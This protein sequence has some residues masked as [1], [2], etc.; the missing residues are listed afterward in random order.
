MRALDLVGPI[1]GWEAIRHARR[2]KTFLLRAGYVALLLVI[3]L[4]VRSVVDVKIGT[5]IPDEAAV[6]HT[7]FLWMTFV[8]LLA[9]LILTPNYVATPIALE[10]E[11]RTFDHLFDTHLS[12]REI[13]LGKW[14]G[15]TLTVL[16]F[17]LAGAPV[18]A[19]STFL[20]GVDPL[21][22]TLLTIVTLATLFSASAICLFVSIISPTVKASVGNGQWAVV[23]LLLILPCVPWLIVAALRA[24]G[25]WIDLGDT[26]ASVLTTLSHYTG[27]A[28]IV[29]PFVFYAWII[30]AFA[31]DP[32]FVWMTLAYVVAHGLVG[33]VFLRISCVRVRAAFRSGRVRTS[34]TSKSKRPSRGRKTIPVGDDAMFW[35]EW[36]FP[37]LLARAPRWGKAVRYIIATIYTTLLL[38]CLY[39]LSVW[40]GTKQRE[41]LMIATV[42]SSIFLSLF[43][44]IAFVTS[45]GRAAGSFA[46]ER[47]QESWILV[48]ATPLTA[49]EIVRAKHVAA[50]KPI[51][52]YLALSVPFAAILFLGQE[53]LDGFQLIAMPFFTLLYGWFMVAL[54]QY[55]SLC[56]KTGRTAFVLTLVGGYVIGGLIPSLL[57]GFL[58]NRSGY[59]PSGYERTVGEAAWGLLFF[60]TYVVL[61]GFLLRRCVLTFDRTFDRT[62]GRI[63]SAGTAP[64][65]S[66][67]ST[68]PNAR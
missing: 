36:T 68:F 17:L 50:L 33:M 8:Q 37:D 63:A 41:M 16:Q 9:V 35:K 56:C 19:F 55:L 2:W 38:A 1:L 40:W 15:S 43:G 42:T 34:T 26:P 51:L 7:F 20:G 11:R 44:V 24:Y 31:E 48:L 53:D 46:N 6:A 10:K 18:L 49:W 29:E 61:G 12:N 3:L 14:I 25:Q 62:F 5:G 28:M 32:R 59:R 27:L 47:D 21:R 30:S 54:G 22:L 60:L 4:S 52:Y 58:F 13:A 45:I 67:P 66:P 23:V 39:T 65:D 57:W 64:S